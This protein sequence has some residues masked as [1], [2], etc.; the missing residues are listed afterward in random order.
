MWIKLANLYMFFVDL[1]K[2]TGTNLENDVYTV[3]FVE[4]FECFEVPNIARKHYAFGTAIKKQKY[5]N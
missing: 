2:V 4:Q 3:G 1:V 5:L